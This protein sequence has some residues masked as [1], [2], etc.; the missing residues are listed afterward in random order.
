MEI[1]LGCRP[2]AESSKSTTH[3]S[4]VAPMQWQLLTSYPNF[5]ATDD[6]KLG[7]LLRNDLPK[8][9]NDIDTILEMLMG[10][11]HLKNMKQKG[12]EDI[13]RRM[14]VVQWLY[15]HGFVDE[16]FPPVERFIPGHIL[17]EKDDDEWTSA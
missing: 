17:S 9:E 6:E 1:M 14:L 8:D 12:D 15:T 3:N 10:L 11:E 16:E 7:N 2:L 13:Q 4:E 5:H